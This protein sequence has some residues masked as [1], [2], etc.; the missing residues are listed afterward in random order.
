MIDRNSSVGSAFLT[1]SQHVD[2]LQDSSASSSP[3]APRRRG[4]SEQFAELASV[5]GRANRSPS[6]Q[7]VGLEVAYERLEALDQQVKAGKINEA[8]YRQQA[9]SLGRSVILDSTS[10]NEVR[11]APE[12]T[13]PPTAYRVWRRAYEDIRHG[14]PPYDAIARHGITNPEDIAR[15]V[16]DATAIGANGRAAPASFWTRM[17]DRFHQRMSISRRRSRD[18]R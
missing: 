18:Y 8:C 1:V 17:L 13:V 14:M 7:R 16:A 2:S 12:E 3:R 4:G 5:R 9:E 15:F 10:S 11:L 6:P